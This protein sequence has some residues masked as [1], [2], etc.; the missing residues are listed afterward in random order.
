MCGSLGVHAR[1]GEGRSFAQFQRLGSASAPVCRAVWPPH[2]GP[3]HRPGCRERLLLPQSG[4]G[5]LPMAAAW[6]SGFAYLIASLLGPFLGG[7]RAT[8]A[9]L[10]WPAAR[11]AQNFLACAACTARVAHST[12]CHT[13]QSA[14][15]A[16]GSTQAA[17]SPLAP[18]AGLRLVQQQ[19]DAHLQW[20]AAS[21][22]YQLCEGALMYLPH[23]P[24]PLRAQLVPYTRWAKAQGALLFLTPPKQALSAAACQPARRRWLPAPRNTSAPVP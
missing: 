13:E 16:P 6:D 18:P 22:A 23:K 2:L 19:I 8:P 7:W 9:L 3:M 5:A 20:A 10:P 12:A 15:S 17:T 14:L 21:F 11:L 24:H 4:A 1:G